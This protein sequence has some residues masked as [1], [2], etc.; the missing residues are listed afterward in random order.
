MQ[1]LMHLCKNQEHEYWQT[2]KIQEIS[3]TEN[4]RFLN[5]F[6]F[7]QMSY[8]VLHCAKI[9]SLK[10][11][12]WTDHPRTDG[13]NQRRDGFFPTKPLLI[14]AG[15]RSENMGGHVIKGKTIS[16]VV[17]PSIFPKNQRKLFPSFCPG[18]QKVVALK[19]KEKHFITLNLS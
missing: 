18:I 15:G 17:A 13:I 8:S 5:F 10:S 7:F 4:I 3:S 19:E 2:L 6:L 11:Q 9:G 12:S 14:S 16:G 1:E